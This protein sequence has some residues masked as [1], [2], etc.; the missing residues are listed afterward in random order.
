MKKSIYAALLGMG[1]VALAMTM[2]ATLWLYYAGVRY[3]SETHLRQ[4]TM[5]LAEGMNNEKKPQEWLEKA[6]KDLDHTL[7]MTW[8]DHTGKVRFE[9][10]YR[11]GDMDNHL[12]RPE[13]QAALQTGE[14]MSRRDSGTVM[15]ET[16]Y[17]A[18]RLNDGS[19][20][21]GALDR[22][23]LAA[24]YRKTLP[25]ILG[26]IIVILILCFFLA[27]KLTSYLVK[28]LREAG[29]MVASVVE[30]K[31]VP[32]LIGVPELDPILA[33]ARDQQ[34]HITKYINQLREE[35][36]T[37]RLMMDTLK[38]GVILVDN[39]RK[40]VEY[41]RAAKNIFGLTR[42]HL[43][44]DISMIDPDT[45][46]LEKF[47]RRE[48]KKKVKSKLLRDDRIYRIIVRRTE[49]DPEHGM[50]VV[51]RDITADQQA[52]KQRREFTSNVSHELNTP[53]TSIRGFGELLYNGMYKGQEEVHNFAGRILK[54]ADRLLGLIQKIMR[55]SKIEETTVN[56]NWTMVSLHEVADQV[57]EL[58]VPQTEKKGVTLTVAGADG[59]VYGDAQLL[60][61][62]ILNLADN[63]VKY[64]VEGGKAEALIVEKNDKVILTFRDTGIGIPE[65]SQGHVFERFYRV[66][67]SRSKET[68]GSGIGL[69]I[70][71]HIVQCHNGKLEL[72]SKPDEG[73]VVTVTLPSYEAAIT[74]E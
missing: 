58:L 8:I 2:V 19:I 24:V 22:T 20:L 69:A 59:T 50:L 40:I 26:I 61:E 63:A 34:E 17:Y 25:S 3:E 23:G 68:G 48:K 64:N 73:T 62:M 15:R 12:S 72:Y 54:E 38:E 18:I 51:V 32:L 5:I 45:N 16:S 70:V 65:D 44:E 33:R 39:K 55:L 52:E 4:V 71:K 36:N 30:G 29:D 43:G 53:L 1:V 67:G 42:E 57:A 13:I 28:P 31:R 46:W 56:E 74:Q 49:D 14:G 9:S 27:R 60:F 66:E 37:T 41:N 21:R 10:A 7:R 11:A 6:V 47:E 35:R